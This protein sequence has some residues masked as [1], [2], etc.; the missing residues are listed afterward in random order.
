MDQ[1]RR[2][3]IEVVWRDYRSGLKS[4]LYSK[5]KNEADVEDLL[6]EV[7][8]KTHENLDTLNSEESLK[9][10]VYQIANRVIIDFYRRKKNS[11]HEPLSYDLIWKEEELDAQQL[12]AKCVEPFL[13]AL[14]K[15]SEEIL[16]AVYL[17]EESQKE[18]AEKHQIKYS[19]LKSRVQK[20]REQLKE[21]FE[22]CCSMKLDH[23]GNL[24]DFEKR[25][26]RKNDC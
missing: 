22:D 16:S 9:P 1:E 5:I 8:I 15:D 13:K 26:E 20:G 12:L 24:M 19:T 7:L 10:W 23:Q 2:S 17:R 11:L 14:P 21:L 18:Y 4:F 3:M 6:Q 25:P